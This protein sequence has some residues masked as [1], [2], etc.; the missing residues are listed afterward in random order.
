[1]ALLPAINEQAT[2]RNVR[3]FFDYDFLRLQQMAHI[4]Y[5]SIKSP[6]ITGMPTGETF[7]NSNDEKVTNYAF[8]NKTLNDVLESCKSMTFPH[9]DFMELKYFKGMSWIEIQELKG[10]SESRG[11][12]IIREAF[13]QF[14]E[15]FAD[16]EDFR[17]FK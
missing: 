16:V 11:Y 1:M 5:V 13:L 15:A 12:Q 2:V 8:A 7:G 17:V 9:R 6:I 4:S 3:H 14:A 10:Y